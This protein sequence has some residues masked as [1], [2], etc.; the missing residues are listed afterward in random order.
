M[1]VSG[2][3]LASHVEV[4][5]PEIKNKN[6]NALQLLDIP[7][8]HNHSSS[9]TLIYLML[10]LGFEAEMS[11][12]VY[13]PLPHNGSNSSVAWTMTGQVQIWNPEAH[14]C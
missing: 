3:V 9:E 7:L 14:T 13:G 6:K 5:F 2:R 8:S 4:Q 1:Q 12:T 10:S 11:R